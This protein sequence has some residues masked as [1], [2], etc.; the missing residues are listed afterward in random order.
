MDRWEDRLI[1]AAFMA[2]CG[3]C[4]LSISLEHASIYGILLALGLLA[5]GEWR[6]FTLSRKQ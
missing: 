5:H 1:G 2:F 6:I 4:G 3:L